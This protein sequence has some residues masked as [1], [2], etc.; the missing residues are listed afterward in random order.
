M[1]KILIVNDLLVGGGVEKLLTDFVER[2]HNDYDVTVMTI[3]K[4]G[5]FKDLFPD[6][7]KYIYKT[8]Q[9]NYKRKFSLAYVKCMTKKAFCKIRFNSLKKNNDFDVVI[10]LK[11]GEVTKIISAFHNQNKFSWYHTDYNHYYYSQFLYGTTEHELRVLK[12][13]KNVVCVSEDIR[14]GLI[15]VLGDAGNYVVKYNPL[16]VDLIQYQGNEP[17]V[18]V[19][20]E[21]GR[22]MFVVVGR[23]N[24]QKGY[25]LLL[26]A[27]HMLEADGYKFDVI[28]VGGKENWGDEYD[29]LMRSMERLHIQNVRFIGLRSNPQKYMKL[30]DWML[31]TSIFEGYSLV[32][33]EA[34]ILGTPLLLTDCSGVRELIGD[35]EY[36]LVVEPSVKGIYEG[37]K[38]VM[39]DPAL[40]EHYKE[41]ILERRKIIDQDQ[42][43]KAIEELI[44]ADQN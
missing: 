24:Y 29:R 31:S 20:K 2:W 42:R 25:D 22:P 27:V 34:A 7:V 32:S 41:Q 33:Q 1:K 30:A 14:K 35:N 3:F 15:D 44:F 5:Q 17:V 26:E 19:K 37:M 36:G 28:V 21:P 23:I 12:K 39:D 18:D 4:Q 38:K 10:A 16:N 6:N 40:H 13:Y 11:D 8:V 9:R 43:F